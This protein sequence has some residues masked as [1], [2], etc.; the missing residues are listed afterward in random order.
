MASRKSLRLQLCLRLRLHHLHAALHELGIE[1]GVLRG[2]L[3]HVPAVNEDI[4]EAVWAAYRL[5]DKTPSRKSCC[6]AATLLNRA[7][8]GGVYKV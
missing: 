5:N 2:R 7:A 6:F 8:I 1:G 4:D 3:C